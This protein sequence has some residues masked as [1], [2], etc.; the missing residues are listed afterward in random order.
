MLLKLLPKPLPNLKKVPTKEWVPIDSNKQD[1]P[2]IN[3]LPV[4]AQ[5]S[6]WT[7]AVVV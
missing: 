3:G 1:L 2:R 4:I 5:S 6:K 7:C